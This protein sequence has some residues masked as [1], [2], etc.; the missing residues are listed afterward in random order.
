MR[1]HISIS[2]SLVALV[3]PMLPDGAI[4]WP[5]FRGLIDWHVEQGTDGLVIMG[6]TG[7]T[8]TVALDEHLALIQEAVRHAAGRIPIIGGTGANSTSEAVELTR[9]AWQA[10][11]TACL[12]VVPYYNK[13]TQDGIYRHFRSVADSCEA[14]IILYDVPG[15]TI[16]RM[17]VATILAL[18][19]LD[20]VVGLKDATA[21]MGRANELLA[22][23]PDSFALYSGDDASASAL[24][25][26]GARGTIS[27]I[28]NLLPALMHDLC[29]AAVS[30]DVAQTRRLSRQ[31]SA[32]H[33]A[34]G[35]ETNPIPVKWA[36]A[37]MGRIQEGIRLPLTPLAPE[38]H[39]YVSQALASVSP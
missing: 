26:L 22:Q 10:G 2:G 4:D 33:Q 9:A 15:R 38:Y 36:L 34:M 18:A 3:T 31:L 30:G 11:V 21:D 25:L 12:S 8:P 14:P 37:H 7:E 17:E 23:L 27:V 29:T 24:M 39:D 28:G 6:S 19:Q 32:V 1:R 13:P 20:G 35:V 5:A 16:S